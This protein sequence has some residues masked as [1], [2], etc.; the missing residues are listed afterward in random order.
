MYIT[1]SY[2][3]RR[4]P[5][6]EVIVSKGINIFNMHDPIMFEKDGISYT[7]NTEEKRVQFPV[8]HDSI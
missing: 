4:N 3:L 7:F 1:S 5:K 8:P 2:F 6:S